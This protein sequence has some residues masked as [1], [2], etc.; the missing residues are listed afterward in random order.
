MRTLE[1][2]VLRLE[3]QHQSHATEMF[4]VLSDPAIYAFEND[5]PPSVEFLQMRFARL[6]SAISPDG[7]EHWL[8]WVIRLPSSELIG[9]VQAT[10]SVPGQAAAIAYILHSRYWG[11][12]LA[13]AAV[14]LMI[15]ELVERY[16]VTRLNAILKS[17]NDRSRRLLER[18]GFVL[19][20]G[21]DNADEPC[22]ADEMRMNRVARI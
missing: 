16:G 19:E 4:V 11:R 15:D 6:E 14:V 18:M 3:P 8:N 21:S 5:P 22:V 7:Q 17:R 10:V 9:Y 20:T 12:G 1:N 2:F 13:S